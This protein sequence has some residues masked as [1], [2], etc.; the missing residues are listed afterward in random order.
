MSAPKVTAALLAGACAAA[1]AA[2]VAV[3]AGAAHAGIPAKPRWKS[4]APFG[5][6][7]NHGFIVYNNEWNTSVAG[8]QTIWANSYRDWGVQS[9][10]ASTTAVKTYPCVQKDYPNVRLSSVT[11]LRSTFTQSMP[12]ASSLDA[13]AAYDLWLNSYKLEVMV[14]VDTRRQRPSGSVIARIR[15]DRQRFSVW[16]SGSSYYA[17]VLTGRQEKRGTV[18]LLAALRW[19]QGHH[20]LRGSDTLTQVNFGWE[21][22]STD[23]RPMDFTVTGYSLATRL[24]R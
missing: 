4:S 18:D 21:I 20:H 3:P 7:N 9:K 1:V 23:G 5:A 2:A 16:R 6:W 11:R 13:E 10:Q 8:P 14:W 17:F 24:R 19:L 12:S 22:A 15:L